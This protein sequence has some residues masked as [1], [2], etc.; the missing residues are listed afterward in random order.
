MCLM[1]EYYEDSCE[2]PECIE[3]ARAAGRS[4]VFTLRDGTVL[5]LWRGVGPPLCPEMVA[6]HED[7]CACLVAGV[8]DECDCEWSLR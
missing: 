7:E 3:R 6:A 4:D 8:W 2:H 5:Y 1:C